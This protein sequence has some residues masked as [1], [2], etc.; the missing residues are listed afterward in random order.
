MDLTI[1]PYPVGETTSFDGI[2]Y[3]TLDAAPTASHLTG[4]TGNCK[5]TGVFNQN[6]AKAGGGTGCDLGALVSK[7]KN[8]LYYFKNYKRII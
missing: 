2:I 1:T 8:E 6:I 4:I 5:Q 7:Q 3:L